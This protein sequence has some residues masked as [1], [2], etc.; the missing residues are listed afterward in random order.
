[1]VGQK[2]PGYY[3]VAEI[4]L[5]TCVRLIILI[6]TPTLK[7]TCTTSQ[8]VYTYTQDLTKLLFVPW[9][10][11]RCGKSKKRSLNTSLKSLIM[12]ILKSK[13]KFHESHNS[14]VLFGTK[15]QTCRF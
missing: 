12:L 5:S 11:M 6:H 8:S 9:E 10:C 4:K 15:D 2:N 13:L 1:M 14:F 7:T 3:Y